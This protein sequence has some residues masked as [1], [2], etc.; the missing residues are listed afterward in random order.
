MEI[1]S[2]MVT[3]A[4]FSEGFLDDYAGRIITDP[5]IALIELVANAWDATATKVNITWPSELGGKFEILD[6]GTGMSQEDFRTVWTELSYNRVKKQGIHVVFPDSPE[7]QRTA[8]G[9]NG[10]GRLSLFCFSDQYQV[11]TWLRERSSIFQVKRSYG[12]SPYEII[13][14]G[15]GAREGHG[16]RITCDVEK[17]YLPEDEVRA[18]LGSKFI[19]DPSFHVILNGIQIDPLNVDGLSEEYDFLIPGEGTVKIIRIDSKIA[20]R[21]S[22]QH[23]VAWW[24]NKRLVGEHSWKGIE[25]AYLDGRTAEA[26][27][28]TFI[29][30]ADLLIDEVKAD[31]T[32]FKDTERANRIRIAV[33]E[34][35]LAS[36]QELMKDVRV[37]SKRAVVIQKK[38]FIKALPDMSQEQVGRFIDDIQIKCP[39]MKQADLANAVEIFAKLESRR[40]GYGLLQKLASL[41]E[42]DYQDLES[43]LN[44]WSIAEAKKVL[45]ELHCRL[46]LIEQMEALVE[47]AGTDELAELQ[48]LFEAGLWIFGPEYESCE[49]TSNRSLATVIKKF[50]DGGVVENPAKRPDFVVLPESSIGAYSSDRYDERSGEVCGTAKVLI[51]ELKCGGFMI[52]HKE[53]DQARNYALEIKNSGKVDRDTKIVCYVLGAEIK[54]S[55][56]DVSTEGPYIEVRPRTYRV[57]LNQAHARTFN[58]MKKI[59]EMKKIKMD[60]KEIES[61]LSQKELTDFQNVKVLEN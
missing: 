34:Y 32:D 27:R 6:N 36:I 42:D 61:V 49:Y 19:V 24:V 10:K 23:G 59:K 46:K 53:K 31:W 15:S 39:T 51:V 25:G 11:D 20:G 60:D 14:Q 7:K 45:D 37:S 54:P 55:A 57:V 28:Y 30:E 12:K 5:K 40:S 8:Y 35:I 21:L 1:R 52:T 56:N 18:L 3:L 4:Q 33:N 38:E 2:E 26:K 22:K 58:L 48:P 44:T 43:I 29:V 47:K 17:N 13:F 16:T 9:R 41:G 50:F